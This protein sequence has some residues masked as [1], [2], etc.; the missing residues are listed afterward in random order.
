MYNQMKWYNSILTNV[1]SLLGLDNEATE[2]EVDQALREHETRE[3]LENGIRETVASEYQAQIDGLNSQL[4]AANK[5]IQTH[6]STITDL[7]QE[8]DSLQAQVTELS[9]RVLED[10]T[11]LKGKGAKKG[12]VEKFDSMTEFYMD[13]EKTR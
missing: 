4:A 6:E 7:I 5:Q 12:K 11:E 3:V 1:K 10:H 9:E 8:R 13:K 2:Q